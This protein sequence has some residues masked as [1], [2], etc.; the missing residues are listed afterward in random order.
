MGKKIYLLVLYFFKIGYLFFMVYI[1]GQLFVKN[2]F[3]IFEFLCNQDSC[4]VVW[5]LDLVLILLVGFDDQGKCM[6]MGGGFYDWIFVYLNQV[7]GY[8]KFYLIGVVYECQ[9]VKILFS[10]SWDIVMNLV[11][12][13][14]NIYVSQLLIY[15]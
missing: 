8:V 9:R 10:E 15:I 13:D 3:G 12:M 11:V 7:I 4:C 5:M 2:C 6:G 1:L 14:Q